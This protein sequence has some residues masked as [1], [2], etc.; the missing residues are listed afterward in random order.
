M[1]GLACVVGQIAPIIK[2]ANVRQRRLASLRPLFREAFRNGMKYPRTGAF[3]PDARLLT[4]AIIRAVDRGGT[5]ESRLLVHVRKAYRRGTSSTKTW[6][7]H[8]AELIVGR[9]D[10]ASRKAVS[11]VLEQ[12]ARTPGWLGSS[13]LAER[14]RPAI[15]GLTERDGIAVGNFMRGLSLQTDPLLDADKV[16]RLSEQYAGRLMDRRVDNIA[17]T[18]LSAALSR[19]QRE[20]WAQ[21]VEDGTLSATTKRVWR[22]ATAPCPICEPMDGQEVGLDEPFETGDGDDVDGPPAHPSCECEQEL[23]Q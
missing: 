21:A 11:A 19:G 5:A 20:A 10:A 23:V 14:L 17:R 16:Q 22:T 1:M 2:V 3:V 7:N 6:A 9:A 13:A 8:R 15:T 12:A 18:E 4:D